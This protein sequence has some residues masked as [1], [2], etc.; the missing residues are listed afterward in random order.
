MA[1]SKHYDILTPAWIFRRDVLV[2]KLVDTDSAMNAVF[3]AES[4][5][6]YSVK[7][8][9]HPAVL[10]TVR[11]AGIHAEVVSADEWDL[12]R[13]VGFT[14]DRI[15]YNGPL[16][17]RESFAEAVCGASL[18]NIECWRELDWL[19]ELSANAGRE[20]GVGLRVRVDL[21]EVSAR[22]VA[23]EEPTSRF[24]FSESAGEF[25]DALSRIARMPGVRLAGLHFHRST[26]GRHVPYYRGLAR[27]AA[28]IIQKYRL[29]LE[30]LDF[31]GGYCYENPGKASMEQYM[32][33][34]HSE[35][36]KAS[37][38]VPKVIVE[39]GTAV[40]TGCFN[41]VTTVIDVKRQ[42]DDT[43]I[44]TI[45]GSRNDLDV[46]YRRKDFVRDIKYCSDSTTRPQIH[47][48]LICGC[49][50]LEQ[51]RITE[52]VDGARLQEGDRIIFRNVG[53][54]SLSLQSD[55]IRRKPMLYVESSAGLKLYC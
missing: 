46:F 44:V 40:V 49:T 14:P 17:S 37:I 38:Q 54:Y 35:L 41:L 25:A 16:K 26:R 45:D 28:S 13:S 12:V 55:F 53:A 5:L 3:G 27:Y 11:D 29:K 9:N 51:D 30:Y 4:H 36:E 43:L 8:N 48:Q 50:C 52:I 23:I 7:T 2:R 18:V 47:K 20:I 6:A 19:A 15:V 42:S 24:G 39:P 10:E 22:D 31:G 1:H 21:R 32:R 34:I 33:A